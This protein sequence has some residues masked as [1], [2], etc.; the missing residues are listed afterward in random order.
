MRKKEL[1]ENV[2]TNNPSLLAFIIAFH[3]HLTRTNPARVRASNRTTHEVVLD[4]IGRLLVGDEVCAA[5][6][7][8]E[9][10]LI[11]TNRDSHVI[12]DLSIYEVGLKFQVDRTGKNVETITKYK[13]IGKASDGREKVTFREDKRMWEYQSKDHKLIPNNAQLVFSISPDEHGILEYEDTLDITIEMSAYSLSEQVVIKPNEVTIST[14]APKKIFQSPLDPFQRR[15]GTLFFHMMMMADCIKNGD[16]RTKV[17]GSHYSLYDSIRN[18]RTRL[19]QQTFYWNSASWYPVFKGTKLRKGFNLDACQPTHRNSDIYLCLL[20][21]SVIDQIHLSNNKKKVVSTIKSYVSDLIKT[22]K[23]LIATSDEDE[24][25]EV[26]NRWI[27][28]LQYKTEANPDSAPEYIFEAGKSKFFFTRFKRYFT[29]NENLNLLYNYITQ[30]SESCN[31][32]LSKNSSMNPKTAITDWKNKK[33]AA[34]IS[35]QEDSPTF[36][37]EK[38]SCSLHEFFERFSKYFIDTLRVETYVK[39]KVEEHHPFADKL[40]DLNSYENTQAHCLFVPKIIDELGDG[41]H[42]EIRLFYHIVEI[43]HRRLGDI[44]YFGITQLCCATCN[45]F[46]TG[47]GLTHEDGNRHHAGTHAKHYPDWVLDNRLCTDINLKALFGDTWDQ[48]LSLEG[49]Y[50]IN[51]QVYTLKEWARKIVQDLGVLD[52]KLMQKLGIPGEPLFPK[53]ANNADEDFEGEIVLDRPP[54]AMD[55]FYTR[56]TQLGIV[57]KT[58]LGDG[59]CQF[60]SA[61]ESCDQF[62]SPGLTRFRMFNS[63]D[64]NISAFRNE[65]V[66][67]IQNNPDRFE[68]F[69]VNDIAQTHTPNQ[70]ISYDSLDHYIN[71]MIKDRTYGDHLTLQAISTVTKRCI[72]VVQPTSEP[73]NPVYVQIIRPSEDCHFNI[74]QSLVLIFN[75]TDHYDI[76]TTRGNQEFLNIVNTINLRYEDIRQEEKVAFK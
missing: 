52:K 1:I 25:D 63:T 21:D 5:I 11:S 24:R 18:H 61:L 67:Y 26:I 28:D 73:D 13:I 42:A 35:G 66:T 23:K 8:D 7:L 2:L 69:L 41:T 40:L 70:D 54:L 44:T 27:E 62:R 53:G 4:S 32:Y 17:D 51:N 10:W 57:P 59:D 74:D 38:S 64:H 56:L 58:I 15:A 47:H 72:V 31:E 71:E 20:A 68:P 65:V 39:R 30:L 22:G 16:Q 76:S 55:E 34:V 48:Y 50:I 46:L 60:R 45:T 14:A 6:A 43:L 29:S 33:Y 75:G 9:K 3:A 37:R 19:L 12:S 49:E 36:M